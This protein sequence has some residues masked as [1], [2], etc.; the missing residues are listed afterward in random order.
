MKKYTIEIDEKIMNYLK[1]HA[2]PFVDSPSSVLDRLLF[3][4]RTQ[5]T[6]ENNFDSSFHAFLNSNPQLDFLSDVPEALSQ[7]LEMVYEVKKGGVSRAKATRMVATRRGRATQTILDKYCRQLNKKASDIDKLLREP[8]LVGLRHIL[9]TKFRNN[10]TLIDYFF[11]R[12]LDL[13]LERGRHLTPNESTPQ[14]TDDETI[15]DKHKHIQKG[16]LDSRGVLGM[17][18]KRELGKLSRMK[19]GNYLEKDWGHF[20]IDESWLNFTNGRNVLC[21]YASLSGENKDRWWFGVTRTY[22]Q[23]WEHRNHLALLMRD[24]TSL[25]TVLLDP[26]ESK[27]LL[28]RIKPARDGQK[29]IN[30]RIPTTGKI[31]L[32]EWPDFPFQAK[33]I[34]LG[35]I[36]LK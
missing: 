3:G 12:I 6:T 14:K 34:Q 33:M 20:E 17:P 7:V 29:K 26:S 27:Q 16:L 35:E 13:G 30:V 28:Y 1:K 11:D 24:D 23:N 22:W 21:L 9:K 36:I 10:S 25:D 19:L 15:A 32:Q 4:V 18:G 31:Y 5:S 8:N 2:E